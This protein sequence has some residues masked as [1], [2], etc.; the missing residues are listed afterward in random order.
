MSGTSPVS[1]YT[2]AVCWFGLLPMDFVCPVEVHAHWVVT[3]LHKGKA[4]LALQF[5]VPHHFPM[6][7]MAALGMGSQSGNGR[8]SLVPLL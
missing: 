6:L 1:V 4:S 3:Q 5:S 7:F 2:Y 8:I